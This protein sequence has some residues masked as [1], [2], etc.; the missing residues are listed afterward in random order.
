MR[1]VYPS[2]RDN[3]QLSACIKIFL[4]SA[5]FLSACHKS[6]HTDL[7]SQDLPE[8]TSTDPGNNEKNIAIDGAITATF[9][10]ATD[11]SKLTATIILQHGSK[12]TTGLMTCKGKEATFFPEND[13]EPFTE[14]VATIIVSCTGK[15]SSSYTWKFSTRGSDS[16]TMEFRSNAV[17]DF[18]RD[19]TRAMQI[20]NY[21]Y[22][23]GGWHMPDESFSDVYRSG[24]DLS[25]W[26]KRPDAPWH[27]RHVYGIGK[28]NNYIYILGGDNLN[29]HFDVWRTSDGEQWTELASDILGNRILFGCCVHNDYLY[30]VGGAGFSDVWRS[31]DGIGWEKVADNIPF[32]GENFAGSLT[33]FNGKLWMVCGGG[34]G[35]GPGE[36]RKTVWSSAD[37]KAWKQEADF[38]GTPRYYNDVCV[39][40]NKLWVIGGYGNYGNERSI[41]YMKRDG[42]WTEFMPPVNYEGRHATGVAVYNDQLVITCGNYQNNC[43]VIKR[44]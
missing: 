26:E 11:I 34:S 42:S 22:S 23:F 20:G 10:K 28:L 4:I 14:Y 18:D 1:N 25:V 3:N 15:Q 40:D 31:K 37:G 17:T 27:G 12:T 5:C 30:V 39:W 38:P 9:G 24:G 33:S 13:L 41:W 6:D 19:G 16:F 32:L 7:S 35:L 29:G 21:L 36:P 2:H 44:D 8:I 43:W